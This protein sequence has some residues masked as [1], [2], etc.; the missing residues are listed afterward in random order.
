MPSPPNHWRNA[1]LAAAIT[2]MIL[3]ITALAHLL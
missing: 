1:A 2:M 3:T